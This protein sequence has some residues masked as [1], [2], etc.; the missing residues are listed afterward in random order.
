MIPLR[1]I[2]SCWMTRIWAFEIVKRMKCMKSI[3]PKP[4]LLRGVIPGFSCLEDALRR[5][6]KDCFYRAFLLP[7][8]F[9]GLS[10]PV[11][12][13]S[14]DIQALL[15][16]IIYLDGGIFQPHTFDVNMLIFRFP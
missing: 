3:G 1:R 6:C 10:K 16:K 13:R 8:F 4:L 11:Q 12:N 14:E 9:E 5:G 15:G 2:L 7:H